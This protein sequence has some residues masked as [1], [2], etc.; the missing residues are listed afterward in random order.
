NN[1]D[2]NGIQVNVNTYKAKDV[3]A[4]KSEAFITTMKDYLSRFRFQLSSI[5]IPGSFNQSYMGNWNK[6]GSELL[7]GELIGKQY[8]Q[9]S[10]LK[11][12]MDE[13]GSTEGSDLEKAKQIHKFITSKIDW[14]GNLGIAAN[15]ALNKVYEKQ[16]GNGAAINLLFAGLLN[17]H[18]VK[19]TPA[20]I[21]TR[22]HGNPMP[23]YP[24]LN[25]FNHLIVRAEVDGKVK[26]FDVSDELRPVNCM[27]VNSLNRLALVLEKENTRWEEI[28][29]EMGMDVFYIEASLDEEGMLS[30]VLKGNYR[31][32]NAIPEKERYQ[33]NKEGAHWLIRLEE[34]YPEIELGEIQFFNL[35]KPNET[36]KDEVEFEIEEAILDG[37]EQIYFDPIIYTAMLQEN[38][39]KLEE[40]TYPVQIPYP[41]REQYVLVLS[42]P[43]GYA[44]AEMP[45][46]TNLSLPNKGGRFRYV[47]SEKEGKIQLVVNFD[48]M[49]LEFSPE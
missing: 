22:T 49:Q 26:F 39:L 20:L 46:S 23:L 45:V 8:L 40:R 5:N 33:K 30:G 17:E 36:F 14:N 10:R 16:S 13:L 42:L 6:L 35:D 24:V 29:P 15:E 12:A 25:Q 21:S 19:A 7:E 28:I 34:K 18:G 44:L 48:L 31:G 38:P 2:W 1:L 9:K 27:R 32:Y 11:S 4:L 47:V 3:P 43:E 41:F 37:G